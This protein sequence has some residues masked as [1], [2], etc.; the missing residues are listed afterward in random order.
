MACDAKIEAF[1]LDRKKRDDAERVVRRLTDSGLPR[2]YREG[3]RGL[4]NVPATVAA[5]FAELGTS[6][7]PGLFLFGES[8]TYKTTV[9]A[10]FLAAAIRNG[11]MGRFVDVVDLMTDIQ[12][13]YRDNDLASRAELVE[14]FTRHAPC[15]VFDDL[16][17]EKA[18]HHAGEVLRQM[19]DRRVDE[20]VRGRWLIV[21]SNR[22]PEQLRDRFE[23]PQT[24]NA[25][26]HRL[27]QLTISVEMR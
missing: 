16:G 8:K 7:L 2:A 24:G 14:R 10:A 4:G 20:W 1:W 23:E 6:A 15:V 3:A 17:Q 13:S 9:A 21:T 12:A 19:L 5:M 26:L 11:S 25:I 18:T 22:T 27:A